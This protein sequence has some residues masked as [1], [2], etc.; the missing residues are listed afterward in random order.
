MIKRLKRKFIILAMTALFVLLAVIVSGM[1]ILNYNSVIQESD[2]ILDILSKNKGDFPE[3]VGPPGNNM[4]Q[5]M[6]PEVQYESRYFSVFINSS[7]ELMR[8]EIDKIA[9]VDVETAI[10]YANQVLEDGSTSGF[11]GE[12]RYIVNNEFNGARITFLDC[13]RKLNA[14][15]RFLYTSIGMSLVGLIVV[16]IVL[17]IVGGRIIKP[18][19]ISYEKQKQFITDA[20]HELKTP[21]TI[22]NANVDILEMEIGEEN[23]CLIDIKQQSDRLKSLTENLVMLA[24]MEEQ[25][26]SIQKIEFPISEIVEDMAHAF[27]NLALQ[28]KKKLE[29]DIQPLLSLNGNEKSISQLVSILLDNS[30]KYSIEGGE[31]KL[32]LKKQG[33]EIRLSVENETLENIG[34]EQLKY[35]FDRFY[36]TDASRNSE[37]GGHGI[38]LS[39]AKAIVSSHDGKINATMKNGNTFV[40]TATFPVL[41]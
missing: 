25:E 28:Q 17:V 9:S 31:I 41:S 12:Y 8:A 40:I 7:G 27:N 3:M 13:G 34:D 26:S 36:R 4:P 30:L 5:G 1:N 18:I 23:E 21:L 35:V 29:W 15:Y 14:F 38:G 19:A 22:I 20:G 11:I 6:S 37:T 33:K 32:K 16:Y 39:V 10:D 2:T 24:R